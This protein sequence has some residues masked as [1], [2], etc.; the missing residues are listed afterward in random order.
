[1]AIL[2][3][4]HIN[5]LPFLLSLQVTGFGTFGRNVLTYHTTEAS[6]AAGIFLVASSP[7]SIRS[8]WFLLYLVDMRAPRGASYPFLLFFLY[9]WYSSTTPFN[10]SFPDQDLQSFTFW[11]DHCFNQNDLFRRIRML[12]QLW[13][14]WLCH[15]AGFNH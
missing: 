11:N 7:S 6:S 14:S 2:S 9:R 8:D 15:I 10:I 3:K 4:L 13:R 5:S 1:M 12:F